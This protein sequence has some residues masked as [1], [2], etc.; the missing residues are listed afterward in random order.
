MSPVQFANR[1]PLSDYA[2]VIGE[3]E[4]QELETLAKPLAG[5]TV[6]IDDAIQPR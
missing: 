6:E 5:R 1:I 2:K 4:I 3:G